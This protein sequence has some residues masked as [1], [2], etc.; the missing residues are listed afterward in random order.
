M[1]HTI[2]ETGSLACTHSHLKGT[3][4]RFTRTRADKLMMTSKHTTSTG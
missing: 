3:T 2:S 4:G 1:R